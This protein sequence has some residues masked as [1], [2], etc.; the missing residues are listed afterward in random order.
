MLNRDWIAARIPHSGRMCLLNAVLE[1][2]DRGIVCDAVSHTA[3]DNPL[4]AAGR[5]GA[6]IG[7]EYAAQA[8]A[9]HGVLM[10]PVA[11]GPQ[12]GYLASLRG[13]R[14]H[15]DRL[16]DLPDPLRIGAERISGDARLIL[17]RFDIHHRERC[18]LE[19]RAAVTF[20]AET[21]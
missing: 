9:V 18:L 6:A 13:L 19:G 16:D 1:W 11:A 10:A 20:K 14:L 4:R 21:A 15:V 7:A 5:L 3:A 8:M 17:Y 2:S 12:Q